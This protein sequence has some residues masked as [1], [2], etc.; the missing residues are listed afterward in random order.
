MPISL[1]SAFVP[2]ALQMLGSTRHIVDVAEKWCGESGLAHA[3]MAGACLHDDMLPFAYQVKSV[4]VHTAKA[5]EGVRK[6]VFSP[7]MTPPPAEFDAMRAKL[8]GASDILKAST[9]EE[10]E[11]FIGQPMRFEM[12]EK[13]RLDF[14]AE[15]FL[16]SFSQ[17]NFYFHAA[18]A[19]DILRMKGAKVG[20]TDFL[21]RMRLKT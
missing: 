1:H 21:G 20:K 13:F 4:A 11:G 16:L 7:D 5:L 10:F 12:G 8:D 3:D 6:G 18:T 14:T 9:E 15:D 17:P 19:Y 2:S